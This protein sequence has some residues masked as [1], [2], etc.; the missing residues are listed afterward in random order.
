M[1]QGRITIVDVGYRSTNF[2]V[3]SAGRSRLLFDLGW[4][5]MLGTLLANLQRMDIPLKEVTHGLASHYHI[6]HAGCAQELKNRGMKLIVT[7][8]QLP[9]IP[10]MKQWTK[11]TDNY[12]EIDIEGNT[13]VPIAESRAC[14]AKIG[15][16]GE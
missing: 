2:W 8:E 13:L 11:P 16:H 6:D 1:S 15:I 14:L 12:V 10:L 4:P 3:I 5:G 9:A 7:P